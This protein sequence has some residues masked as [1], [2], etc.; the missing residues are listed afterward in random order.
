MTTKILQD[1]L[2]KRFDPK[3]MEQRRIDP[4]KGPSTIII[5]GSRG[6]G[7]TFLI[8]DLMYYFRRI[9]AGMIMTGS[10]SSAEEFEKFFP[11]SFIFDEVDIERIQKVVANQKKLRKQKTEGDYSS[12]LLFDDCGY[13]KSVTKNKIIKEI[14]SN[15][16]HYKLLLI[17]AVQYCKDIPPDLRSNADYIFI[18]REPSEERRR[19]LWKEYCSIIPTFNMFK[20]IMNTCT[21]NRGILVIDKTSISNKVEDGVFWYKAKSEPKEYKVGN[22]SL[23]KFHEENYKSENEDEAIVK[24]FND[25]SKTVNIKKIKNKKKHHKIKSK[26]ASV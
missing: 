24:D 1:I 21:D 9:P 7:K 19:A 15:G 8:G 5:V 11:K 26:I 25:T 16:R 20:D 14:F 2:L 17:M 18:M 4:N 22:K 6:T 13:D 12:L 3:S 10:Q 23:W